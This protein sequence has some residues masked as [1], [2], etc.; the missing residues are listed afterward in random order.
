MRGISAYSYI[1]VS[2]IRLFNII[3]LILSLFCIGE[4]FQRGFRSGEANKW[5][6]RGGVGDRGPVGKVKMRG[7]GVTSQKIH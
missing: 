7:R 5:L 4:I 2:R 3:I 1:T 6:E